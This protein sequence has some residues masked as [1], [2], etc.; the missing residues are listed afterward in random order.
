MEVDSDT[1]GKLEET[2]SVGDSSDTEGDSES[3]DI[4]PTHFKHGGSPEL[5]RAGGPRGNLTAAVL[6]SQPQNA[7]EREPQEL[8]SQ[9]HD[10]P[11]SSQPSQILFESEDSIQQRPLSDASSKVQQEHEMFPKIA[12]SNMSTVSRSSLL[13]QLM[14]QGV[15]TSANERAGEDQSYMERGSVARTELEPVGS[16]PRSVTAATPL[17]LRFPYNI[18]PTAPS[19]PRTTRQEMLRTEIS[20]TLRRN[21]LWSRQ[22]YRREFSGPE[23]R[24]ASGSSSTVSQPLESTVPSTIQVE[25]SQMDNR[26]GSGESAEEDDRLHA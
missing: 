13:S 19:S 23:R 14:R 10:H 2:G 7:T 16:V 8:F 18:P 21:L 3:N 15:N 17:P 4:T 24:R 20:E 11:T 9:G 25:E 12:K 22:V 6:L 5:V 1:G 26:H